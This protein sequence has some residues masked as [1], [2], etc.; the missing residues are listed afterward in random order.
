MALLW[1]SG[2]PIASMFRNHDD[3]VNARG[4]GLAPGKHRSR[5]VT[6]CVPG[7][8]G[9]NE[10][11]RFR[12]LVRSV[13]TTGF[14]R[15]VIGQDE[16]MRYNLRIGLIFAAALLADSGSAFAQ[17]TGSFSRVTTAGVRRSPASSTSAGASVAGSSSARRAAA[18]TANDDSLRRY[19]S[20]PAA[21]QAASTGGVPRY[22]TQQ[23]PPV[24]TREVIAQPQSRNYYPGMRASR[25][26]QQ[27]VTLT[28][29]STGVRHICTPSR[30]QMVGAGG[31]H[32]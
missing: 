5:S 17:G 25:A 1:L 24:A 7:S 11:I 16:T 10:V 26:I 20:R 9:H 6:S 15:A 8:L 2:R 14:R 19:S 12:V 22:S 21:G 13:R 18:A 4:R 30:S 28:A 31:A 23:E 27:P 32:R 3:G 29:R